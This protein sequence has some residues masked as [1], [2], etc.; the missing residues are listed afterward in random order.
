M[1]V[2]KSHGTIF[3]AK[4]TAAEKKALGI[5][6][7]KEAS[8]QERKFAMELEAMVIWHIRQKLGWGPKRL[9]EFYDSFNRDVDALLGRYELEDEDDIPDISEIAAKRVNADAIDDN[10]QTKFIR[11]DEIDEILG[12]EQEKNTQAEKNNKKRIEKPAK[13]SLFGFVKGKKN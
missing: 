13:K 5:E 4:L 3:G 10:T 12:I 11:I 9:R 8:E 6:I 7:R 2:L 1:L